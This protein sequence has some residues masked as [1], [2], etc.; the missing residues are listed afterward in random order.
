LEQGILDPVG[1]HHKFASGIHGHK[2]DFDL[3]P[4]SEPLYIEWIALN[5]QVIR[6]SGRLAI[7]VVGVANGTN[8]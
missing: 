6:M 8:G 3:I 2:L 1:I 4:D 7:T 5:V